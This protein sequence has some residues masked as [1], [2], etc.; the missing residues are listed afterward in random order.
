MLEALLST[1][2]GVLKI[3]TSSMRSDIGS[4]C[5]EKFAYSVMIN[6]KLSM[7][8]RNV[9]LLPLHNPANLMGIEAMRA[10]PM[11]LRLVFLIQLHQT[12]RAFMW[13]PYH[14]KSIK[15]KYG[16]ME[17]AISMFHRAAEF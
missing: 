10:L 12:G 8:F 6:K 3:Q 5:G 1:E 14:Y 2:H 16:F 7:L 17:Q 11:F 13:S 9:C 4:S 15:S